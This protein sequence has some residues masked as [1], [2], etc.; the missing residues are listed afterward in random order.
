MLI[1]AW[2]TAFGQS[3]EYAQDGISEKKELTAS[4]VL[5][6]IVANAMKKKI[7]LEIYPPGYLDWLQ[8]M[9]DEPMPK[10]ETKKVGTFQ[11]SGGGV[12]MQKLFNPL[13][14]KFQVIDLGTLGGDY[15]YARGINNNGQVVGESSTSTGLT[16]AFHWV[17]G[18]MDNLGT[19]GGNQSSAYDINNYNQI[20]GYSFMSS[21]Y[22]R[23]FLWTNSLMLDLGTLG[24]DESF[25]YEINDSG[26][27]VG[28]SLTTNG[29]SHAY[30]WANNN[31]LDIHTLGGNGSSS[32]GI[33]NNQKVVGES[34]VNVT[35][36]HAFLW[37][38]N[39]MQDLGTLSGDYSV[40]YKINNTQQI[41]GWSISSS[42]NVHG[43]LKSDN[44]MSDL[45]TLGGNYSYAY[46]I[47]EVSQIVG[48]SSLD[49]G[50]DYHAFLYQNG[51]MYDLNDLI[52]TNISQGWVLQI[53]SAI[54]DNGQIVGTGLNPLGQ[55]RAFLLL[56]I[57]EGWE[58]TITNQTVFP[59][60]G[61]LPEREDGKDS[62]VLVTHGHNPDI[63]WLRTMTNS[64]GQYLVS[65][66]LTNWQVA[67]YEWEAKAQN[68]NPSK[69]LSRAKED[70][71][72]AGKNMADDG[73]VHVH[74]VAHSAGSGFIRQAAEAMK[75]NG[76]SA[77]IHCTFLDPYVGVREGGVD[78]FG[79]FSDWSDSYFSKGDLPW[80]E[81]ILPNAYNVEVT[82]LNK[83]KQL[84]MF[85][86]G[87]LD[88]CVMSVA[89]HPWPHE[90]YE[91]TITGNTNSQ[92]KGF[93]FP[94][95]KEGGGW[96][97]ALANYAKGGSTNL[98]VPDPV[99]FTPATTSVMPEFLVRPSEIPSFKSGTLEL[100]LSSIKIFTQSPSW[101]SMA[102]YLTNAANYVSFEAV[103]TTTNV[104][105]KGLAT[106]YWDTN[107]LGSLDEQAVLPGLRRYT[108]SFPRAEANSTHMLGFRLD[109]FTNVQS[110]IVITNITLGLSGPSEPF[111]LNVTTNMSGSHRVMELIGEPGFNYAIEA[112][113][114][115]VNWEAI[116]WLVNT[117][118]SVSFYD[119][120]DT[121]F[122]YRFYRAVVPR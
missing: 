36:T 56:P 48:E 11:K 102:V 81:S 1:L 80:T 82:D 109:P 114:N 10:Q 96:D 39:S 71:N 45:E 67:G 16:M 53:A 9:G 37:E 77:T 89:S 122:S 69:S 21:G 32:F 84:D 119:S 101:I 88:P 55:T 44:L 103:F 63:T 41:I 87:T 13:T 28:G 24:G 72:N 8:K 50:F 113:T 95:S 73:W 4:M 90:Y 60:Y 34:L 121:N 47:N 85:E 76:S 93:G 75:T 100:D 94:L 57:P 27:I 20:V 58:E 23:A 79:E 51:T 97:Y 99:C 54:N 17:N 116:A 25:A 74:F 107:V 18:S 52:T 5:E 15:S 92:Y 98:G 117:N 33:N 86:S 108:Y 83:Q 19:L 38:N 30:L 112:S 22:G 29:Y 49:S 104:N 12:T 70:G 35:D 66:N 61:V 2:V 62:L 111:R 118:N 42:G 110:S 14:Q 64:M 3:L 105:P 68:I 115:L 120:D 59:T 106:S 26:Q 78:E 7:P 46:G 31:M 40:A 43:F 6:D 65:N 91:N